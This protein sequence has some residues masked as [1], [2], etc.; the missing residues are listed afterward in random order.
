MAQQ[1]RAVRTRNALI[2]SAAELFDRESFEVVSLSAISARA[3]VS[4]GALHFHFPSKA[5]LADAVGTA[6]ADRLDRITG[7]GAGAGEVSEDACDRAAGDGA[8]RGPL[9]TLVDATHA[10]LQ[11]LVHDVVLRAGFGLNCADPRGV[12]GRQL[13]RRWH[14]YVVDVLER[15]GRD[16]ELARDVAAPDAATAVVAATVGFETMGSHDSRWLSRNSLTRF[17]S[18]L[19]PR[20]ASPSAL[21]GLVASGQRNVSVAGRGI[22]AGAP[23]GGAANGRAVVGRAAGGRAAGGGT[24]V[25]GVGIDGASGTSAGRPVVRRPA[26]AAAATTSA[27][28]RQ[29]NGRQVSGRQVGGR[30]GTS[31][32]GPWL[33]PRPKAAGQQQVGGR[34]G[35][36]SSNA[37]ARQ[38]GGAGSPPRPSA[39][40]PLRQPGNAP[41]RA[42]G[43]QLG[44]DARWAAT[45]ARR[46]QPSPAPASAPATGSAP[47]PTR[48]SVPDPN[49]VPASPPSAPVQRPRRTTGG[50]AHTD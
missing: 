32:S 13:Y 23:A 31:S 20:L 6:A 28:R 5:A 42:N 14:S 39:G 30:P 21:S 44:R 22:G 15:A 50:S 47:A 16:G 34:S 17:W 19:L 3:G 49:S 7:S 40:A 24:V 33:I 11:G 35:N 12:G 41:E 48:A 2:V 25:G 27:S 10:L 9:Q 45:A 29:V 37:P 38:S 26:A 4:S 8:S 18:L 36:A 1:E 43:P 46:Q